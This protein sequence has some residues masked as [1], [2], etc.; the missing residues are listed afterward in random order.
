MYKR[1]L[2]YKHILGKL[3]RRRLFNILR[4]WLSFYLS[5]WLSKPIVWAYPTHIAV[6][7]TTACNLRC[8][9]CP[10]GLRSFS[11]PTGHLSF[12]LYR[13][14]V[15]EISPLATTLTLYF[16]G[17]PYLHPQFTDLVR[18][19][20]DKALFTITSTNGH[21][22]NEQ[23]AK[24]TILSG[25]DRL[26]VSVDGATQHTY[27]AYRRGGN[28][29]RVLEGIQVLLDCRKAMS[30]STPEVV[31][32]FL[33]L[34]PNE[35]EIPQIRQL[36]RQLGVDRLVLKTAQV[37]DYEHGS[38]LIPTLARYSRYRQLSD[39]RYVIK[40]PLKNQCWRMWNGCVMTW[41]G[42]IVPCCFDK[43][44]QHEL[45]I[46]SPDITFG[47]IWFSEAYNRFRQQILRSRQQID[48]CRNCSEGLRVWY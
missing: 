22:L 11:R 1:W 4:L 14:L 43:D 8:P 42:R 36:A 17:E 39:G 18:Y 25:L 41:D 6:E 27:A 16:Q 5:K 48:I 38:S 35:H 47:S 30:S 7:P 15:D 24:K 2:W 33:V 44:A 45:G 26:I 3:T 9:E 12:D 32:Q 13:R 40:N 10:S 46:L 34:R 28:L 19:A 21:F 31:L 23:N 37:Y 29:Q 20:A